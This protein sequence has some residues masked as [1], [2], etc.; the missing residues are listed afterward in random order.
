MI[1]VLSKKTIKDIDVGGKK[2]LV[3]C[4]FNVP[5][6]IND[7]TKISDDTRIVAVMPTIKYL[8]EHGA[9]LILCSH[10]GKTKEKLSLEPVVARIE[11]LLGKKIIFSN[12]I[13]GENVKKLANELNNG[14]VMLLENLRIYPEEEDCDDNFSKELASLAEIYV[15]DAFGTAHRAH[16]ST[17]GVTK[18]LPAV[19]GFLIQKELKA[20][21]EGINDPKRPFVAIIGGSKISS[22]IGVISALLDKVDVLLIGGG[23]AYTFAKAQGGKI[24]KSIVEDD[25][26]ELAKEIM[27]RA[28]EKNVRL[29]LPVDNALG[30]DYSNDANYIITKIDEIPDD[31]EG[32]DIGPLTITLFENEIKSAGTIFWNGTLGVAEFPK[33]AVGTNAIA[34]ALAESGAVTIVG[35]GDSAAAVQ[36]SGYADKITH[37]STG[38]GASLEFVEGKDL[39]G[40]VA[41][42]DK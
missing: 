4:D 7:K 34:K 26:L 8:I 37:I 14:D 39:P 28:K 19:C 6:D 30:D 35:G 20:L 29:I 10:I 21:D 13:I 15:N 33:Y 40:I 16:S 5:L 18:Y 9:K 36:K 23:M 31:Y 2:V 25:K 22:K 1:N 24:G 27:E 32:L 38:G 42:L 41:L 3:R 11:E 12:E 17:Y